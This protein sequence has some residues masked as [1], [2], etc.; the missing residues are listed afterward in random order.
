MKF[1]ERFIGKGKVPEWADFFSASEFAGFKRDLEAGLRSRIPDAVLDFD[2]Q[3]YY[4]ASNPDKVGGMANLALTWKH[5]PARERRGALEQFLDALLS[6]RDVDIPD[7]FEDAEEGLILRFYSPHGIGME[8]IQAY[9]VLPEVPLLLAW[10]QPH[11]C[12]Y[13][14]REQIEKWG[15]TPEAAYER[16]V[17]NLERLG[18]YEVIGGETPLGQL[19]AITG[20]FYASSHA[21]HVDRF[22]SLEPEF[23]L[24]FSI[25]RRDVLHVLE[26][27]SKPT[28]KFL[29]AFLSQTLR[30]VDGGPGGISPHV[31]WR[32]EGKTYLATELNEH[33]IRV[34][35]PPGLPVEV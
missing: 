31:F 25:P 13:V 7:R 8:S 20:S 29:Q 23:G 19:R 9:D 6:S 11:A 16:A 26:P 22:G 35:P 2:D 21:L 27:S 24:L 33:G 4:P 34:N 17:R 12:L 10:D 28:M 14:P 15:V 32:F 5:A 30:D 1:L 18:D 3:K